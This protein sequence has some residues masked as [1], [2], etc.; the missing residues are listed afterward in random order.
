MHSTHS[1]VIFDLDGREAEI[2]VLDAQMSREDFWED[3]EGA[4]EVVKRRAL[5]QSPTQRWQGLMDRVQDATGLLELATE[6]EDLEVL[7]EVEAETLGLLEE[8]ERFELESLLCGEMDASNAI[9]HLQPG[10]G[11]PSHRTGPRC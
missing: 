9:V 2:A 4:Q 1:E 11:V 5:L 3:I 10:A 6:E 8:V 7:L